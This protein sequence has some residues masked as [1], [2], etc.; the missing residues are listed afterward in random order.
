MV[1]IA[2]DG[3]SVVYRKT[4]PRPGLRGR[5]KDLVSPVRKD[6][7]ALRGITF[8]VEQGECVAYI[9]PN[10][11]RKTTTVK[12]LS[13]I[14]KPSGGTVRVLN[15]EPIRRSPEFLA[16]IGLVLGAKSQLWPD[17]PALDTFLFLKEIYR[18]SD[19][20]FNTRLKY[21]S[22][23]FEVEGLVRT[24]VRLLSHG[25]R[26]KMQLIC[27]VL[28]G[29]KVLFMDEPTLGLDMWARAA[30]HDFILKSV[31]DLGTTVLLTSHNLDDVD[32]LCDWI[33]VLNEGQIIYDG[34]KAALREQFN[35]LRKVSISG[36]AP[37]VQEGWAVP[38]EVL[39]EG[40]QTLTLVVPVDTVGVINELAGP[41]TSITVESVPLEYMI[42]KL[43]GK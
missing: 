25:E 23:L 33:I 14:L 4:E 8:E 2:V 36:I 6:V 38:L 5:L 3:L 27:S 30:V 15:H 32:R 10:G 40:P 7:R 26:V 21:L 31:R 37:G 35:R 11:S 29:P 19:S 17:L 22:T 42:R 18:L 12:V 41:G 34:R 43:V 16:Q 9:G 28:H 24:P 1:H 20:E 39:D 13:G